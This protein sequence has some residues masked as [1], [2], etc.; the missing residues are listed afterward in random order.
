MQGKIKI[1]SGS[2]HRTL[3]KGICEHLGLNLGQ[4]TLS[5]FPN[6]EIF[7]QIQ[8]NIRGADVFLVQPMADPINF[9]LMELFIMIDAARRASAERITAVIPFYAYARQDRKDRPRVPITS[10]LIAN[11][12]VSSGANRLLTMELHAQQIVGFFDLPVDHLYASPIFFEY[13]KTKAYSK[14]DLCVFSPDLGGIKRATAYADFLGCSVGMIAKRRLNARDVEV[15]NVIGN[16]QDKY[17]ILVDDISDTGNT[18]ISAA[19]TLKRQGARGVIA[20]IAHPI[21]AKRRS[22][23]YRKET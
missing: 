3:A 11:L 8:E 21:T 16:A 5:R 18:L 15:L 2:A 7:V 10:K 9:H 13:L 6:G 23:N 4:A 19:Q 17:V 14:K 22:T 20:M 1:F 12:L